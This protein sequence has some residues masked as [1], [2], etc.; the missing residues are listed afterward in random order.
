MRWPHSGSRS[1]SCRSRANA[2]SRRSRGPRYEGGRF[3]LCPGPLHGPRGGDAGREPG[4]PAHRG[5]AVPRTDAEPAARPP[6]VPHRHPPLPGLPPLR[7]DGGRGDVRRRDHPCG[8]RGWRG[9][10]SEPGMASPRGPEHR[11]PGGPQPGHDRR[12]PRARGSGRGLASGAG[13]AG[14][15]SLDRGPVRRARRSARLVPARTV[16]NLPRARRDPDRGAGAAALAVRPLRLLQAR[17]KERRV[18]AGSRRR[19]R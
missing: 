1:T 14:C 6:R 3:R 17:R 9:A 12:E 5:R 13:R 19:A 8:D 7:G 11:L 10:R 2:C 4:Q 16:R 15:R 18:R